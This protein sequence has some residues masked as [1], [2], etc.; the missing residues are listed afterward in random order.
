MSS[1]VFSGTYWTCYVG[2]IHRGIT[3]Y[4]CPS[5]TEWV[6]DTLKNNIACLCLVYPSYKK[7]ID[8]LHSRCPSAPTDTNYYIHTM[9]MTEG[10]LDGFQDRW[11]Y[12]IAPVRGNHIV[13]VCVLSLARKD[14]TL[15]IKPIRSE[16]YN[17]SYSY[18]DGKS[19]RSVI[20]TV[21][22]IKI[23]YR[24][25]RVLNWAYTN[26]RWACLRGPVSP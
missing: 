10:K 16:R 24:F 18:P 11:L 23:N 5:D 22:N 25:K 4:D 9:R 7:I 20:T 6:L 2:D 8:E 15:V 26:P 1:E 21:L 19:A 17:I 3:N 13:P 12:M 14:T